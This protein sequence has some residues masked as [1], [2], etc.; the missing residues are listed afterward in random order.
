MSANDGR[1]LIF[2]ATC[3]FDSGA[4]T[5]GA[6]LATDT[7]T[8]PLEFRCTSAVRPTELQKILYGDALRRHMLV[9]LIGLP[10]L[11][12]ASEAADLILVRDFLL[13][14]MRTQVETPVLWVGKHG[15]SSAVL[16]EDASAEEHAVTSPTGQFEPMFALAHAEHRE[17]L[18]GAR[19]LLSEVAKTS[20]VLEPF[21]RVEVAL[22]H[23]H[24][25]NVGESKK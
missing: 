23:V 18:R 20:N 9:E 7:L 19:G 1:R 21:Q 15:E 3:D 8:K 17:E 14:S 25:Q 2:L 22:R 16:P 24:E 5:R 13:L 4:V 12:A 10:L 6:F 11:R